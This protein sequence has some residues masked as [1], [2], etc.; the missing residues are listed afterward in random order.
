MLGIEGIIQR[1]QGKNQGQ[2]PLNSV[3]SQSTRTSASD[4][5]PK[6]DDEVM[7]HGEMSCFTHTSQPAPPHSSL[8]LNSPEDGNTTRE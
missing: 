6:D 8:N 2:D 1:D 7:V 4:L 3:Y 5:L